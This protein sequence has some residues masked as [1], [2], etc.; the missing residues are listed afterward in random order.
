MSSS[1]PRDLPDMNIHGFP[2]FPWKFAS[3]LKNDDGALP[4]DGIEHRGQAFDDNWPMD[5]PE[6]DFR[7]HAQTGVPVGDPKQPT[8]DI[9]FGPDP[10]PVWGTVVE[11]DDICDDSAARIAWYM[12]GAVVTLVA[13]LIWEWLR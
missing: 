4:I 3:G 1:R 11:P 13:Y 6:D 12:I 5:Y 10:P 7:E 8:H 9:T 2:V